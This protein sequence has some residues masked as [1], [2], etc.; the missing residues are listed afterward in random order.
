FILT[1]AGEAPH[2]SGNYKVSVVDYLEQ[3]IAETTVSIAANAN[4][5]G[6]S[7]ISVPTGTFGAFR[8]EARPAGSSVLLA[9]QIYSVLPPLP[10]PGERPDSYFGGHVDLTPYNLE[11]ARK[12]GFRWLRMW[13]PLVTTWIAGEPQP[14]VWNFPTAAVANAYRQ[15]FRLAG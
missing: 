12:S 6:E 4:G 15:G 1:V 5:Y 10:P 8:I 9:E 3:K 2:F 14:G 7:K 11:I 13:P